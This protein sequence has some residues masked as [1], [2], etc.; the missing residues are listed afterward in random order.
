MQKCKKEKLPSK[1]CCRVDTFIFM[2][3]LCYPLVLRV[4]S[5]QFYV[6]TDIKVPSTTVSYTHIL[7]VTIV[8]ICRNV[9]KKSCQVNSVVEWILLYL[10]SFSV[11]H[12]C[13]GKVTKCSILSIDWHKCTTYNCKLHP[14]LVTMVH[15]CRNVKRKSYQ[16]NGLVE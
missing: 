4:Q 7:L 12:W 10:C 14:V 15:I 3:L 13:L 1:W 2:Q 8:H 11:T 6:L 5:A 16:V 9:R